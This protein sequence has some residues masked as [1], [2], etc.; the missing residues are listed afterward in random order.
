MKARWMAV[1]C[2]IVALLV[3]LGSMTS[4][5]SPPA[6]T[7]PQEIQITERENGRAVDLKGEVLVLSLKSNPSTGYGW[8]VR[9]L[10]SR[11]L[12]RVDD[13]EWLPDVPGKLGAPG[14]QVLRFAGIGK[15]QARLDLVYARP[16]ETTAAPAQSFSLE[17]RVVEPSRNVIDP[18]P[19][20]EEPKAAP[21][22]AAG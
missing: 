1:F 9:G 20:A 16:W 7:G 3:S 8:Q 14:T 22:P 18:Q 4:A 5:A 10:D 2:L 13:A 12:R 19:A 17:V 21:V 6:F 15:G 11:I